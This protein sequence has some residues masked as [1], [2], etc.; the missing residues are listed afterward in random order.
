MECSYIHTWVDLA[1]TRMEISDCETS[2]GGGGGGKL[3]YLRANIHLTKYLGWEWYNYVYWGI[4]V[5]LEY[6]GLITMASGFQTLV[7]K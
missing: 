5:L 1:L 2:G 3:N 7:T 6:D 4:S